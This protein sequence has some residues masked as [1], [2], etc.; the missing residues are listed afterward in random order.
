V[1]GGECE[2]FPYMQVEWR[3]QIVEHDKVAHRHAVLAGDGIDILVAL[4]GDGF[5]GMMPSRAGMFAF[6]GANAAQAASMKM[7]AM[8]TNAEAQR[9]VVAREKLIFMP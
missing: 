9:R 4:N 1:A 8:P 6:G 5:A 3:L 7:N 2:F